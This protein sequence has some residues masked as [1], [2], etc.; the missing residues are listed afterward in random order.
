M[1]NTNSWLHAGVLRVSRLHFVYVLILIVQIWVYD[2]WHLIPPEAVMQ[3]WIITS[4][5]LA[6][7]SVVWYLSHSPKRSNSAYRYMLYAL[8]LVDIAVASFGVYT[9]RGMASRAVALYAVPIIV[10]AVLL[11]RAALLTT[12]AICAASYTTA[13]IMYFVLHFN[14]GYKIEL[15]GE[16]TFYSA[17]FF[18]LAMLLWVVIKTKH[19]K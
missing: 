9:Q 8:I 12:A 11:S 3:R 6:V 13:A 16:T 18:L 5:L 4:V 15:Y 2:A 17:I 1:K 14:E 7:T 10:S 19:K